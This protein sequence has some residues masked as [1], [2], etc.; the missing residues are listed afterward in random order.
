MLVRPRDL[1]DQV[2]DRQQL[3]ILTLSL[4]AARC[5]AREI[6]GQSPRSGFL[7]VIEKWRQFPTVGV[8]LGS[9]N[10]RRQIDRNSGRST[11]PTPCG[12]VGLK[13]VGR[14]LDAQRFAPAPEQ[15][16]ALPGIHGGYWQRNSHEVFAMLVEGMAA[17]GWSV[18]NPLPK[19]R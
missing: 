18:A 17:H 14:Q 6:I 19:R 8:N 7:A 5:K 10:C 3:E 16:E 12:G 1:A 11:D 15:V 13:P 2:F 4:D 9:G